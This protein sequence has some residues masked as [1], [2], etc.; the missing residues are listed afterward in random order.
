M[1]QATLVNPDVHVG[2]QALE[3]LDAAQIKHLVAFLMTTPEYGDW[4]FVL[5]S[6]SFDQAHQIKAYEKV[7]ELLAGRF[8]SRLPPIMILPT[9]DPLIKDLRRMFG[10]TS[11]V[12]GTRLGGQMIGNRFITNGYVFR[13]D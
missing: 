7:A 5:S 3:M 8:V 13:V 11:D 4:R 9:K 6:P 10:K 12:E 2:S 1:D